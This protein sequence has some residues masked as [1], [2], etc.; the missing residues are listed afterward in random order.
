MPSTHD[1]HMIAGRGFEPPPAATPC[2]D[3]GSMVDTTMV[4]PSIDGF[5]MPFD[6]LCRS[7]NGFVPRFEGHRRTVE[8]QLQE[9]IGQTRTPDQV[10]EAINTPD[11]GWF[12]QCIFYRS[13]TAFYR[14]FALLCAFLTLE[15]DAF[16][17][18]AQVTAYYCRFFFLQ[19]F[20]NLL[21]A[22]YV[23]SGR[24]YALLYYDGARLRYRDP[25]TLPPMMRNVGSH[26]QW[27]F[28]MEA[29]KHPAD[30]PIE[31]MV[32]IISRL[33]FNPNKRNTENY[34]FEY[35]EGSP[36]LDWFDKG[37]QQ[38]ISHF[39]PRA[40]GDQDITDLNRYFEGYNPE[41][42]DPGDFYT[43]DAVVLWT[44]LETYL[45]LVKQ[46]GFTEE[47]LTTPIITAVAEIHLGR[48]MPTV[49]EGIVRATADILADNFNLDTFFGGRAEYPERKSSFWPPTSE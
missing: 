18:W 41:Y 42:C 37:A 25:R 11:A 9:I 28:L 12:R 45:R 29:V 3:C 43:D 32:M 47:F 6:L 4:Y 8:E 23:Y 19:A 24:G 35:L 27:W 2:P 20:L 17:T 13:C 26:E 49:L 31:H 16:Q 36:E 48:R 1:E 44:Y 21:Q 30:Y 40:R 46:L 14:S 5:P 22:T 39:H 33:V 38:L 10:E 7:Y 34:S 15:R